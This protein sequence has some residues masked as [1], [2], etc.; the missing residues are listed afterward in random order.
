M[1]IPL[2][3]TVAPA[4]AGT[5]Q[6][7]DGAAALGSPV[8]VSGG[9]ATFTDTSPPVGDHSYTAVFIPTLGDETGANTTGATTVG[10]STS[11]ALPFTINSGGTATTTTVVTSSLNPSKSGQQVTYTA[12]VTPTPDAGNV[13]FAD[14]GTT[15][16]ACATEA[17]TSGL[18][19][20][21]VTYAT[22]G[23]HS[24]T[25]KY[26]GNATFSASTSSALSQLVATS[27]GGFVPLTPFRVLDTRFG[28]GAPRAAVLSDHKV[29]LT[30]GGVDGIPAN[31]AGVVLNV[32]V[33]QPQDAGN[34][35]VYPDTTGGP[36]NSSNLNFSANETIPNLVI[37]Q[38]SGG[39]V[40]LYNSSAG[41]VQLV[42][43]VSGWI[44]SGSPTAPGGLVPMAPARV[45]DTRF[46]TGAPKAAVLSDHKVVLTLGGVDGIPANAAAVVL[47][48]TVTQPQK[49]GNISVYPDTAGGPPNSSNLNFSTNETI[50]NLVIVQMS[51]GKVDLYNASSGTVQLVADVS[52]YY[53][54]GTPAPGGLTAMAPARVL[55]TRFGTGAPKAAVLSD[56]K[57]VLTLG[58]VDGIPANAAAVVLNVTVTQPQN[59]GNI[60][61]YPDTTGGP[62]NSSNLNF[63]ANE[64]IPNLVI[65]Q[66]SGGKVDLYNSS[67]GTVQL[68]ADVSGW[69][70]SP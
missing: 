57:V 41:T 1:D 14:G 47:N 34:I 53:T 13:T 61:V 63:S 21:S 55:D 42:A 22:P 48:V 49:A 37:V 44:A 38:L 11:T 52:G 25:A 19:T 28:T 45:L 68:V 9:T 18:S 5:V 29:V 51:G 24:I 62:P 26:L 31:A 59:A 54:S 35:S 66:L 60:S 39:K 7:Y 70:S 12:T 36:P 46:G 4:K 15:I 3:A 50:P 27:A 64:T 65:V 2:K 30:L 6:F 20:C 23:Q 16:A 32:T 17:L 58:G 33:T 8:T 69:M 40:D 56:H 67:A 10:G 43:D